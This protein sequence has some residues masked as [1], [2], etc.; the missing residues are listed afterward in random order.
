MLLLLLRSNT[1]S[2][3]TKSVDEPHDDSSSSSGSLWF[4]FFSF[5][6]FLPPFWMR[7]NAQSNGTNSL[8]KTRTFCVR[9]RQNKP[10]TVSKASSALPPPPPSMCILSCCLYSLRVRK[11][12]GLRATSEAMRNSLLNRQQ[13]QKTDG[14]KGPKRGK[15]NGTA[16]GVVWP[17]G[18]FF[19]SFFF[20]FK[21][22]I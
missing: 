7:E 9:H 15:N 11:P 5:L 21:T 16:D 22:V 13:Q 6:L 10:Q 19:R 3:Q 2:Q 8:Q 17:L 14:P 12:S 1:R 18:F 20:F 4:F